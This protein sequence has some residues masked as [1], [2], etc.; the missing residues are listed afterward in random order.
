MRLPLALCA[1]LSCL[2]LSCGVRADLR[3]AT[4]EYPPY[5]SQ[6]LPQ[7]GSI[8][9]LTTRAFASQGYKVQVDF[10][11][12]ARVRAALHSGHYQ[13]A[14]ALWPRE[15]VE[16]NL[17]ASRPLFYS[18]LGFFVRTDS[19][20]RFK[21]LTELKGRKVGVVRGYGYPAS[22]LHSGFRAEEAVD[23]ISNL[24]KLEA[25]RFDL[26]LLE[27]VVGQYLI[28]T[29]AHLR[30]KLQ[31]QSPALERI[32]LLAGFTAPQPGQPDWAHVYER[33]LKTLLASGEYMRILERQNIPPR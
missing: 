10:L 29:D 12:W 6:Y 17:R 4:L 26:V 7:G 21:N 24:R 11:P 20:V 31:W 8:V 1:L 30:G 28:A 25:R 14:L 15:V 27:R 5:C 9:E 22:V 16:E 23:D 13:G 18:E 19:P 33:G 3:L 32:P 2:F